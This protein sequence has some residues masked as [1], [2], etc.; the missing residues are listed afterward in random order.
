MRNRSTIIAALLALV[1]L[2]TSAGIPS[3]LHRCMDAT[4]PCE[5]EACCVEEDVVVTSCCENLPEQDAEAP[6]FDAEDACCTEQ[7]VIHVAHTTAVPTSTNETPTITCDGRPTVNHQLLSAIAG[8][9]LSR[10]TLAAKA[11]PDAPTLPF[12]GVLLI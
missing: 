2:T 5:L 8:R 6:N 1:M 3:V 12:L 9:T 11:P 7:V 10:I 4:V